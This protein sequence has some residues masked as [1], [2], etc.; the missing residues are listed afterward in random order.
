MISA[1]F[2]QEHYGELYSQLNR[3]LRTMFGQR[4]RYS[5]L[6]NVSEQHYPIRPT[7]GCDGRRILALGMLTL[8]SNQ[9]LIGP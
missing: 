1:L 2:F 9:T 3:V 5:C 7:A 8:G 4:V 6:H